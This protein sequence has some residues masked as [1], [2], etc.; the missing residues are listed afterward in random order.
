MRQGDVLLQKGRRRAGGYGADFLPVR[1][2]YGVTI[3]GDAALAHLQTNE[4]AFWAAGSADGL[5]RI[6]ADE[7]TLVELRVAVK[8]G[9]EDVDVVRDFVLV[10]R[11]GRFEA[12]RIAR[13]KAAGHDAEFLTCFE[14]LVPDALARRRIGGHVDL[15]AVFSG[16]AGA[17]DERVVQAADL[18]PGKPVV[19]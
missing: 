18:A 13:A 6:A 17:G 15:E 8:M 3:P 9:F 19:L 2:K 10:E 11:H 1:R 14:H 12:Q 16:I 5:K 7:V 4:L